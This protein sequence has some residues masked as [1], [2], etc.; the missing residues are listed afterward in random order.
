MPGQIFNRGSTKPPRKLE[1]MKEGVLRVMV[2]VGEK[3]DGTIAF[4]E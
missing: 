1:Q 2:A 4:K 3:S